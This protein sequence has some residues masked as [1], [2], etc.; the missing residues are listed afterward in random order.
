MELY[1]IKKY[2]ANFFMTGHK[3]LALR[4]EFLSQVNEG[5]QS[6]LCVLIRK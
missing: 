3:N 5:S 2:D 4:A 1:V 6:L